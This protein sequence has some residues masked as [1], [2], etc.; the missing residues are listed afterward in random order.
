M[1]LPAE[2]SE[3]HGV[4]HT[5]RR[6]KATVGDA[7]GNWPG[8]IEGPVT[9]HALIADKG[10]RLLGTLEKALQTREHCLRGT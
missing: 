9:N 6:V 10:F 3:P 1:V 8:E 7:Y 2:G 4:E 5:G